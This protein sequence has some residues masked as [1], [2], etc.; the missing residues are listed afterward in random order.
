MS[1]TL[2]AERSSVG[3]GT[4]SAGG[5]TAR[6]RQRVFFSF[7]NKEFLVP[8]LLISMG[9]MAPMMRAVGS[10]IAHRTEAALLPGVRCLLKNQISDP[11]QA[12]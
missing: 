4:K 3:H 12:Y 7:L 5:F 2:V 9:F 11:V 1:I 10:L 8:S 6:R